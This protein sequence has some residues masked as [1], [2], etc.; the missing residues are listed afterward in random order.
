MIKLYKNLLGVY[1]KASN[2]GVYTELGRIPLH[3]KICSIVP[4][5]FEHLLEKSD[6]LLLLHALLS[7]VELEKTGKFS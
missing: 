4:K 1:P 7:E 2:V 3:V 6:N 5:F